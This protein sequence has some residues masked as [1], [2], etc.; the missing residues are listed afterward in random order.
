MTTFSE[1]AVADLAADIERTMQAVVYGRTAAV[2]KYRELF[3]YHFGWGEYAASGDRGKRVRP[4]LTLLAARAAGGSYEGALPAAA[5][6][7]LVH[8]FSLV[9]D[10]IMDNDRTRRHR[11]TLWVRCGVNEAMTAGCALY[12]LAFSAMTDLLREHDR[13]PR[14]LAAV[15]AIVAGCV[16]TQDAQMLDLAFESTFDVPLERCLNVAADRSALV[17]AAAETGAILG[18]D[19]ANVIAAFRDYGRKLAT[20]YTIID[21]YRALWGSADVTGKPIRGDIRQRKK[22]YPVLIGYVESDAAGRAELERLYAAPPDETS[23]DAV[24]NI[25]D[26]AAAG[27]RTLECV[28]RC[29]D[30]ALVSLH[31]SGLPADDLEPLVTFAERL[32]GDAS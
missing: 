3:D 5:A 15:E 10:D 25:L 28:A 16:A 17:G 29:R 32:L 24:M 22:T 27:P 6:L 11:P 2:P 30:A 1:P 31:R 12:T 23:S 20:G 26:G 14:A 19:D 13:S 8:D 7:Q 9:L 21:D 4:L 18:T